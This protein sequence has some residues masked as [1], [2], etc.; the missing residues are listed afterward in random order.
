VFV[1]KHYSG[2]AISYAGTGGGA[3]K[4]FA[5]P[6]PVKKNDSRLNRQKRSIHDAVEW[7]RQNAT[8]RPLIFCCTVPVQSD[9][10]MQNTNVSKFCDNI[11]QTYECKNYVWVREYTG[12]GRPHY[13]FV[14]D[15]PFMDAVPLSRYW[16]SLFGDSYVND[17]AVRMGTAPPNRKFFVNSPRMARY[18]TKYMGKAIGDSERSGE[19]KIR[20]FGHSLECWQKSQPV[21]YEVKYLEQKEVR[22]DIFGSVNGTKYTPGDEVELITDISRSF[23]L[24]EDS[25]NQLY[26]VY[27]HVPDHLKQF[28]DTAYSWICPNPLHRVYYGVPK[29]MQKAGRR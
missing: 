6:A 20:T 18:L 22:R 10:S 8:Y 3:R 16:S 1:K 28:D 24:C 27:G 19:K 23:T 5:S 17:H 21:T 2:L 29:K 12:A 9:W 13:H 7:M 15:V 26:E 25:A 11:R 4:L 14:A